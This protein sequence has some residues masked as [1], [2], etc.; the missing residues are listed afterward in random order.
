MTFHKDFIIPTVMDT[1]FE[2]IMIINANNWHVDAIADV[3]FDFEKNNYFE[4][5]VGIN[6]STDI[7]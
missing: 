7:S 1:Y 6:K 3:L 2:F 4:S 5:R